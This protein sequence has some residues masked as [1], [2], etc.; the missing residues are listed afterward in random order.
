MPVP[1]MVLLLIVSLRVLLDLGQAARR[2]VGAAAALP[3]PLPS[4]ARLS[5]V[6]TLPP[7]QWQLGLANLPHQ[8]DFLYFLAAGKLRQLV[9]LPAALAPPALGTTWLLLRLSLLL[10]QLHLLLLLP[11]PLQPPLLMLQ[12]A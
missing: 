1:V 9:P 10:L 5:P 7:C 12:L 2:V 11:P 4:C 8:A 6:T 3:A